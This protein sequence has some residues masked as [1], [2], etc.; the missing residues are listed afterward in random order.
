M[1]QLNGVYTQ[2]F[3]RSHGRS[4]HVFQGRYKA[5]LV[6]KESHLLELSR[7]IVRN[8][9][10]A[11][12]VKLA[13][14]WAWSSYRSTAGLER[15]PGFGYIDWILKQFG[16]STL[17]YR[18][19]VEQAFIEDAPLKPAKDSHVLGSEEFRKNAQK[20]IKADSEIPRLQQHI[21]RLSLTEIKESALERGEWMANA[22]RLHGYTMREVAD[23]DKVHYSL[24]S[25][26]IKAWEER[27]STF[28]T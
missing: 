10:A 6:E 8:P 23:F 19:Y 11:G 15:T 17:R 26:T 13:E 7:Y 18:E 25:K 28:K 9:V 4:G 1:R 3:N 21:A 14:D 27:N 2:Q 24:V 16:G 12:M 20:N 5:I 22:Y